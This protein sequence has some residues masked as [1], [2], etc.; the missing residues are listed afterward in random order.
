MIPQGD[1]RMCIRLDQIN[2]PRR[3]EY[4]MGTLGPEAWEFYEQKVE[5]YKDRYNEYYGTDTVPDDEINKMKLIAAE[6]CNKRF[7]SIVE[8]PKVVALSA[9]ERKLYEDGT[10]PVARIG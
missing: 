5:A 1:F 9:A 4:L 10:Y 6:I 3:I 2:M 8:F 7:K